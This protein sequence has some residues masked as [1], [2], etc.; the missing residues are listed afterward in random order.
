MSRLPTVGGDDNTWG[1]ILNDFLGVEHNADGSQKP[2]DPTKI[3]PGSDGQVLTTSSGAPAWSSPTGGPPSGAAAGDLTGTYPNPTVANNKITEAKLSLS[4][5]A[6][7][8]ASAVAHGLLPKLPNDASKFMSGTGAWLVPAGGGGGSSGGPTTFYISKDGSDSNDG[9]SWASPFLTIAAALTAYWADYA[10]INYGG[11]IFFGPGEWQETLVVPAGCEVIGFGGKGANDGE[12]RIKAPD[13]SSDCVAFIDGDVNGHYSSFAIVRNITTVAPSSNWTGRGWY[14]YSLGVKIYNCA[15]TGPDIPNPAG[16]A[17]LHENGER[18]HVADFGYGHADKG[19]VL[20]GASVNSLFEHIIGSGCTQDFLDIAR[21]S[22]GNGGNLFIN[23]KAVSNPSTNNPY[24]FEIQ[25]ATVNNPS[26]GGGH[27]F[28]HCDFTES[29]VNHCNVYVGGS[30]RNK[31]I[32][33]NTAQST[34]IE[35]HSD[36]NYFLQGNWQ[37]DPITVTGNY[38]KFEKVSWNN[39]LEVSG[40]HNEFTDWM[41]Q[42]PVTIDPNAYWTMFHG[43]GSGANGI[44]NGSAAIWGL[45]INCPVIGFDGNWYASSSPGGAVSHWLQGMPVWNLNAAAGGPPGWVLV[46]PDWQGFAVWKAMASL[47]P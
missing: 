24:C 22:G 47:A 27:L 40:I 26:A 30:G 6:T 44:P 10:N 34:G 13:D 12:T 45:T 20:G 18:I 7:A 17:L 4:D 19:I 31:F 16:T 46:S 35:V 3:S 32:H 33:F 2:L 11:R 39:S 25:D 9:S 37:G 38:N 23:W 8:N 28:I 15:H 43:T 21:P 1:N 5:V 29:Y 14:I 36:H 42:S 41:Q